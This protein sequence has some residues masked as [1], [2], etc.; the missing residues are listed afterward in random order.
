M[1]KSPFVPDN[2]EVPAVLETERFRLRML[3]VNDVVKDYEAVMTSKEHI[4]DIWGPGWPEGLTLEQNLIDLGWHQKEFQRRR[5]FAYTVVALDESRVLGCVYI[6]PTRKEGYDADD[7][8]VTLEGERLIDVGK[9][10]DPEK[11]DGVKSTGNIAEYKLR[12]YFG[13]GHHG[14]QMSRRFVSQLMKQLFLQ[15]IY[16]LLGVEDKTFLDL[17]FFSDKTFGIDQRLLA[18]I[19]IRYFIGMGPGDFDIVTEHLIET[20]LE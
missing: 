1:A 17:H 7:M 2:F 16:L 13:H 6:Y 14:R 18:D 15:A 3:T 10:I 8:R 5:S 4:H 9:D 19:I 20:D 12:E 11:T